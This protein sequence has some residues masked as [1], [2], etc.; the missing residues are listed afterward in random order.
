M[1][2]KTVKESHGLSVGNKVIDFHG[3]DQ[4]GNKIQLSE[5]L[6]RGKVVVVFLQGSMVSCM[7]SSLEKVARWFD[8]YNRKRS[9]HF[10]YYPGKAGEYSKNHFENQY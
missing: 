8:V 6:K 9:K 1:R 7:Y 3:T 2:S 4:E 5:L 10:D